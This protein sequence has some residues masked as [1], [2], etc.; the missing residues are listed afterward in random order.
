MGSGWADVW[1]VIASPPCAAAGC[2]ARR[3]AKRHTGAGVGGIGV[4][5]GTMGPNRPIIYDYERHA[6]GKGGEGSIWTGQ[7]EL[8]G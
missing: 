1:C 7:V 6:I 4:G 5:V 3:A 2:A 8:M